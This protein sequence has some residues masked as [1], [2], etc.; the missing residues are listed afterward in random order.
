M[1]PLRF[2]NNVI[3]A[4]VFVRKIG[5]KLY[6]MRLNHVESFYVFL[7]YFRSKCN[8]EENGRATT[9][10]PPAGAADHDRATCKGV[11][12]Y[13][14]G[15][16]QRG[17]WLRPTHRGDK[18]LRARSLGAW[19]PQGQHPPAAR[20]QG[21]AARSEATGAALAHSQPV[22]GRRRRHRE[23]RGGPRAF[24]LRKGL[25]CPSKLENSE[26]SK[27]GNFAPL[28]FAPPYA[29]ELRDQ[30]GGVSLQRSIVWI[31]LDRRILDLLHLLHPDLKYMDIRSP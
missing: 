12:G 16:L 10:R 31:S 22:E 18:R 6:V 5:F 8:E 7:L 27:F 11:V 15:P 23:G 9:A 3:R 28:Y 4:K 20:P 13:G 25:F 29:Q 21:S 30:I 24:V 26:D 1:H 2:S 17:D 14:Q 19:C